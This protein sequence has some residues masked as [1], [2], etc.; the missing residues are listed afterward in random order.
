[1]SGLELGAHKGAMTAGKCA[2]GA[3]RV[4]LQR[5]VRL[6]TVSLL[7]ALHSE[8]AGKKGRKGRNPVQGR[9]TW[10]FET[11]SVWPETGR[12]GQKLPADP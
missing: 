6:S 12:N 10:V 9:N 1:M 7:S 4:P 2:I 11:P 3:V 5:N 8:S